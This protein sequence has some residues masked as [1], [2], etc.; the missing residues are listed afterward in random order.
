MLKIQ[1][2]AALGVA[3]LAAAF[4]FGWYF[5]VMTPV[6]PETAGL[7]VGS[8]NISRLAVGV[9]FTAII[10]V[11]IVFFRQLWNGAKNAR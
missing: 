5:A 11:G 10:A 1:A 3:V 6:T 8:S 2:F 7:D 4:Y 9:I